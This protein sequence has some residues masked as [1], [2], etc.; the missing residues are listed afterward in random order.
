VRNPRLARALFLE[1]QVGRQIGPAHFVAVAD[2]Y[3]MLRRAA[4][5]RPRP[6]GSE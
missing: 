3:I 5:S 6:G 4:A 2:I 1:G